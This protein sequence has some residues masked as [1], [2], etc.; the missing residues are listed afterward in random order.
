M[1]PSPVPTSRTVSPGRSRALSSTVSRTGY[2]KLVRSFSRDAASPPNRVSSS[3]RCH[4]SG[5]SAMT[6]HSSGY[7]GGPLEAGALAGFG[8]CP[9]DPAPGVVAGAAG[10]GPPR[11]WVAGPS[12]QALLLP[13][14][15][16]PG[17][18]E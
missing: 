9:G 15:V 2:N 1:R 8:L 16:E 14:A 11:D 12:P 5:S 10:P 18:E 7:A 13:L 3:H 4:R 17:G 6:G